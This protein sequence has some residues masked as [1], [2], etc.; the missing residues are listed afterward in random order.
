MPAIRS[1]EAV[2]GSGYGNNGIEKTAGLID[3][4]GETLVMGIRQIPLERSGLDR[5]DRQNGNQDGVSTQRVF[6]GSDNATTSFLNRLSNRGCA[7]RRLG[8]LAL[9]GREAFC[10]GLRF[11]GSSL[12]CGALHHR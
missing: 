5:I 10:S 3:D 7:S 8:D 12:R 11:A 2:V 6:V 1:P 9:C 4:I